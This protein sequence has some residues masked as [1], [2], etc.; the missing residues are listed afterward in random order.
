MEIHLKRKN[1]TAAGLFLMVPAVVLCIMALFPF[2]AY[3]GPIMEVGATS[4]SAGEVYAGEV[5]EH[6]FSI[7][8]IGDEPLEVQR[9]R[10]S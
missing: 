5:V 8:N 10:S 7:S 1:L 3:A 6:R 4:Y 9:V 2:L